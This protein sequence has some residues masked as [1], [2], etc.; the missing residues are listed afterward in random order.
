MFQKLTTFSNF[1]KF[2]AQANQTFPI[3]NCSW[4]KAVL[5]RE[6]ISFATVLS[7]RTMAKKF[8]K[9]SCQIPDTLR[10]TVQDLVLQQTL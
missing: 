8:G 7:H 5:R 9:I 2:S 10:C 1:R 4:P 6:R 3:D